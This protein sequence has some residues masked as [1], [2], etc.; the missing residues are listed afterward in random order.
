MARL[1]Q[2]SGNEVLRILS[3]LGYAVHQRRG[4]NV[5][6]RRTAPREGHELLT[7]T[8]RDDMDKLALTAIYSCVV[9]KFS[10]GARVR[11][12]FYEA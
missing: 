7:F 9:Q 4:E 12:R 5:K 3:D 6:L 11:S 2:L 10:S 8:L 1:R